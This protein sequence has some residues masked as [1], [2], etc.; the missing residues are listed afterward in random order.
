[1]DLSNC[2][3][4]QSGGPTSAINATLGGV[5]AAALEAKEIGVVYGALNGI[6]GILKGDITDL[7][8]TFA[9]KDDLNT[10]IHTPS[11]FL[12]SCRKKLPDVQKD[13]AV[14]EQIFELFKQRNIKYFFYI[15]GNDSMDTAHKLHM[16]SKAHSLGVNVIGIPKTVD[17]DLAL[18][19]HTPGFGS[20]AK[21]V[22]TNVLDITVDR[23]SY[24][25]KDLTI[26]EIMGRNA[27]WLTASAALASLNNNIGSPQL[28][29]LPEVAFD[30]DK[31]VA[32]VRAAG[33]KHNTV[34]VCISE[35][36]KNADGKYISEAGGALDSFGHVTLSGAGKYLE[37]IAKEQLPEFKV[38]SVELNLPQRCS[39]SL[40]SKTDLDESFKIGHSAVAAAL[41][42][43]SGEMMTYERANGAYSVSIGTADLSNIANAEKIVPRDFINEAG[44]NVTQKCIDYMLPLIQGEVALRYENGMPKYCMR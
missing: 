13:P 18:T 40:A 11:A 21:F 14:Y 31:F 20:A 37:N 42:G 33:E 29:Y 10:L 16:Y 4:G 28:I 36:L 22:A 25:F 41:N 15:G 38:R 1:M 6:S 2:I 9:N 5:I 23:K 17:N 27:G 26:I 24:D 30:A 44:N 8:A 39:I 35:G 19:D 7:S 12:G 43:H 32:D 34:V 3:V